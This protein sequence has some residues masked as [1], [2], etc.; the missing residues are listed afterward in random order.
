[1]AINPESQYPGKIAPSTPG[2]PYGAARNITVPGD[3]TGTPWEAALVNDLFGFQ[4]AL[5]TEGAVVPSGSPDK[6]GASQYLSALLGLFLRKYDS[7][8][9]LVTAVQA[10]KIPVGATVKTLGYHGGWA[11]TATGTPLGGNIYELVDAG[12]PGSRPAE[13]GGS[14]VHCTGGSGGLYLKGLFIDDEV[15]ASQFGLTVTG[16]TD[17]SPALQAAVNFA[18]GKDVALP[19]GT[20]LLNSTIS[21]DTTGLGDTNVPRIAG[22]GMYDTVIDN[23]TGAEAF[24]IESGTASEFAYGF[25]LERLRITCNTV[26]AGTIGVRVDG[27]RF[28]TLDNVFID[29]QNLHG[30]YGLS[31]LGDFTDTSS[32]QLKHVQIESCGGYGIYA[33]CTGGAIQYSWNLDQCRIGS[34]T[35]GGALLESPTNLEFT[36]CGIYYNSGF[37]VRVITPVGGVAPKLVD[38]YKCEFDTNDGLQADIQDGNTVNFYEPYLIANSGLPTVFAKGIVVGSNVNDCTITSSYPRFNPALVGL[39]AHE[40]EAGCSGVVVRDT[41]YQGYSI[42]NGDMYVINEPSVVI[43][44]TSNRDRFETGTYTVEVKNSSGTVTSP[45]TVE[46][47]YTVNGNEVTVGFRNLNDIDLTG[48]AGG[49]IIV[50][51]LPKTCKSGATAG[52]VGNCVIT[53]DAGSGAP[54]PSVANLSAQ[55][56]FQRAGSNAFVTASN[57]TGGVSDIAQFTLSYIAEG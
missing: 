34:N 35:L 24:F 31:S 7:L 49:D 29:R 54:M 26:S 48:F 53:S 21:I 28:V 3:G 11:A 46:G 15:H 32:M 27:C 51:T 37:G 36:N 55:A 23:Q 47:H 12:A 13:D 10:G 43:D 42:S 1:M 57:L 50:V 45:T 14:V 44:D 5:L 30:L 56:G 16:L 25:T 18:K 40:F 38:F 41:S 19:R 4:Q 22:A 8:S 2:Y 52:F 9:A 33:K 17:S 39:V 20:I 6:V